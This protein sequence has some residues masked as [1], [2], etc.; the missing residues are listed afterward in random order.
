[1]NNTSIGSPVKEDLYRIDINGKV[2]R[3]TYLGYTYTEVEIEDYSYSTNEEIIAFWY[4]IP[5][6]KSVN[7]LAILNTNTGLITDTC[8]ISPSDSFNSPMWINE[9]ELLI[10]QVD[11]E[12]NVYTITIDI[13]NKLY[14]RIANNTLPV[15]SMHH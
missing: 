8:F 13:Y 1:M 2:D 11:D 5:E 15:G 9:N 7:H 3:L 12:G 4:H 10:Y 6:F 14:Y